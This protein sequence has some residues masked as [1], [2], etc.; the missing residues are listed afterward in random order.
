MGS[1]G[2]G[3]VVSFLIPWHLHPGRLTGPPSF[4]APRSRLDI[5]V[6]PPEERATTLRSCSEHSASW[7]ARWRCSQLQ[8]TEASEVSAWPWHTDVFSWN[9]GWL[10]YSCIHIQSR[11]FNSLQL[12]S[13]FL[14]QCITFIIL[15]RFLHHDPSPSPSLHLSSPGSGLTAFSPSPAVGLPASCP[16]RW[17]LNR[18][19]CSAA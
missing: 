16:A 6:L 13:V 14:S 19:S 12:P 2:E 10:F 15:H 3:E 1:E 7:G 4:L 8:E 11:Y 18:L 17:A 5:Y 9:I